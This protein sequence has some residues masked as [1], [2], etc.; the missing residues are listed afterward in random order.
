MELTTDDAAADAIVCNLFRVA[1]DVCV[2]SFILAGGGRWH[3][4]IT[5]AYADNDNGDDD[6]VFDYNGVCVFVVGRC[7]S[8]N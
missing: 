4:F 5:L 3:A 8:L 7:S 6:D 2:L 1:S